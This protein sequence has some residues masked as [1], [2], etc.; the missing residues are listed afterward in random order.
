MAFCI[1]FSRRSEG[2]IAPVSGTGDRGF[3]S[4]R[5][6]Q[7]RESHPCGDSLFFDQS[8]CPTRT[9]LRSNAGSHTLLGDR[10]ACSPDGE[11][12]YIRLGENPT[13]VTLV[14]TLSFL[15]KVGVRREHGCA[16]TGFAYPARRSGSLLTRRRA[17]VYSPWR[18]SHRAHPCGDS[19]FFDQSRGPART[20]LRSDAGSHTLLGDRGA[21]SPGGEQRYIRLGENPTAVTPVVTLSFLIKVGVRREHG[22]VSTSSVSLRLPPSPQGEG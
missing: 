8:R 10:G 4:H 2:G 20:R 16:A 14:V 22:C 6:D 7:K 19:L 17:E 21:C 3:E 9:R 11:Q 12:R 13:A 1:I 18:K 5:F 15:I